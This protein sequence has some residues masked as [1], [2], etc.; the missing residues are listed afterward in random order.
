LSDHR[1]ACLLQDL[2]ARHVCGFGCKVGVHD[3]ALGG[4]LVLGS[5]LQ[6]GDHCIEAVL[7]CAES[8]ASRVHFVQRGVDRR[9]CC[10][11]CGSCCA[12]RSGGALS[13]S[14]QLGCNVDGQD[15][16]LVVG[17]GVRANLETERGDGCLQ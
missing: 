6:V 7:R 12:E 13:S 1:G 14:G 3:A 2:G 8:G 9:H 4:G 5:N 10:A 16:D 11:S 15:G 17:G